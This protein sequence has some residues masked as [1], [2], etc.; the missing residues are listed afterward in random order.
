MQNLERKTIKCR[1]KEC[2]ERLY[3]TEVLPIG[4]AIEQAVWKGWDFAVENENKDK[5]LYCPKCI[6]VFSAYGALK[7]GKD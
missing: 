3:F 1:K 2:S 7:Y 6:P 4:K 5:G